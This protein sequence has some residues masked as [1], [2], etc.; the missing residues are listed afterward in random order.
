MGVLTR[1]QCPQCQDTGRDNLVTHHD[2]SIYCYGCGYRPNQEEE[3]DMSDLLEPGRFVDIKSRRISKKTCEKLGI[4]VTKHYDKH[5]VVFNHFTNGELQKQKIR[6][7]KDKSTCFIKGNTKDKSLF[8]MHSFNP[9]PRFFVVLTEGEFDAAAIYESTGYAAV[10]VC[11]GAQGA[12][13]NV[14]DNLEW[15]NRWKYVVICMD[16]DEV[17]RKA[18][19]ECLKI[20]EP[21]KARLCFM[22]LKD[23]NDMLIANREHEV[24]TL[25]WQA[26][27]VFPDDLVTAE[28][29]LDEIIEDIEDGKSWP[30]PEMTQCTHGL[31]SGEIYVIAAG[32]SVGKSTLIK[33]LIAHQI[34]FN[35]LKCGMFSF[36]Q[37][38]GLTF[39]YI[40][41][42]KLNL[43]LQLPDTKIDK[44]IL[45]AEAQQLKDNLYVFNRR[46]AR[47]SLLTF[48][49][50]VNKI[51]VLAKVKDVKLFVIDNLKAISA[52]LDDHIHGMEKVMVKL[53]SLAASLDVTFMVVSHLAKDKRTGKA[54]D[55]AESWGRGR[56]PVLEN[57]YGSSAIEAIADFVFALSRNADCEDVGEKMRTTVQCLKSRIDGTKRGNE[58]EVVYNPSTGRLL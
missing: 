6:D 16:N 51:K 50:I 49:D 57:I 41:G 23:A 12:V 56:K 45:K 38:V 5:V 47:E 10:S 7:V 4:T 32:T 2:G 43:P 18:A 13:K 36:E 44:D 46:V 53:Q 26:E 39:K 14:K 17:G 21:G 25:L 19:T 30:Y 48:D 52:T 24:K 42:T 35:N 27:E 29:V 20:F 34:Y 55:E 15:L 40:L 22:P 54:G 28:D 3:K 11:N 9:D 31:R 33:E 1:D 8:G 58:F 37:S